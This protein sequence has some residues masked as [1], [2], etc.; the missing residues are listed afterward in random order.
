MRRY[1][2]FALVREGLRQHAGWDRAWASPAPKS[3]YDVVAGVLRA[4]AGAAGP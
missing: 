2:V 4:A 1:S 3:R